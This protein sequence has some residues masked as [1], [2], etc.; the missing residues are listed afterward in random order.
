MR[1]PSWAAR[2][3][4]SACELIGSVICSIADWTQAA[5]CQWTNRAFSTIIHRRLAGQDALAS[6]SNPFPGGF[7]PGFSESPN[8]SAWFGT[9]PMDKPG[10]EELM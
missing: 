2:S 6:G 5:F 4:A 8:L 3:A 10:M 1:C 7:A 9:T